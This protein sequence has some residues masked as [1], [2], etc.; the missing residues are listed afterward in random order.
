MGFEREFADMVVLDAVTFNQDWHLGNFGFLVNNDTFEIKSFAP[1][2]D[3][4]MAM[5]CFT[6]AAARDRPGQDR[7]T[8]PQA[9]PRD[10]RLA[11]SPRNPGR[12]AA[13]KLTAASADTGRSFQSAKNFDSAGWSSLIKHIQHVLNEG[14]STSDAITSGHETAG[15]QSCQR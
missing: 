7:G 4:N 8:E 15:R 12:Q 9:G 3:F 13:R 10:F 14:Q 2:F 5:L 1:L 6:T 11:D